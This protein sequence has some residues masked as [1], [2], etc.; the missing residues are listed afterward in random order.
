V[1][2]KLQRLCQRDLFAL[3]RLA[4]RAVGTTSEVRLGVGEALPIGKHCIS[5]A[6]GVLVLL[7][8]LN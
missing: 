7:R 8:A 4:A 1:T 5:A 2:A 3:K 6:A